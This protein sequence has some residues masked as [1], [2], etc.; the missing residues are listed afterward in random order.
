M[1]INYNAELEL[2]QKRSVQSRMPVYTH[3]QVFRIVGQSD[4]FPTGYYDYKKL[5]RLIL[6]DILTNELVVIEN[7]TDLFQRIKSILDQNKEPLGQELSI[8]VIWSYS[9]WIFCLNSPILLVG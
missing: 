4:S 6:K 2:H 1:H 8:Y 9:P 7:D 5:S 3:P